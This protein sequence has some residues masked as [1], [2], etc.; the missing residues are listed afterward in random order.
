MRREHKLTIT[1]RAQLDIS[2]ASEFYEYKQQNLSDYFVLSLNECLNVIRFTPE[3]FKISFKNYR[4]A[5]IRNF[6]YI[7]IYKVIDDEIIVTNIFNTY[8]NPIKKL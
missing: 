7:V 1:L 4:E 2:D 6:P 3:I 5:K 8:Q